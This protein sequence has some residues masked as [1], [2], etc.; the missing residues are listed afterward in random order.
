[1]PMQ[2]GVAILLD[3]EDSIA[4]TGDPG[5]LCGL[6]SD[7]PHTVPISLPHSHVEY[8]CWPILG[9]CNMWDIQHMDP[10]DTEGLGLGPRDSG[11]VI[12]IMVTETSQ[13][14][15][16]DTFPKNFSTRKGAGSSQATST[17]EGPTDV[18]K[19]ASS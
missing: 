12:V 3:M 16:I 10:P 14:V 5:L 15:F 18:T 9:T 11:R 6:H 2:T 13:L 17:G 1:M 8:L 7:P 4:G 19:A